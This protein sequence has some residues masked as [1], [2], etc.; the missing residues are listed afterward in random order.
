MLG[1]KEDVEAVKKIYEK[2]IAELNETVEIF[3][4][5]NPKYHR[6][7]IVRSA[8]VLRDIQNQNGGCQI[9]FPK[10]DSGDSKV[11][12]KGSKNCIEAAKQKI[13]E[14]VSDLVK[15]KKFCLP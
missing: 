4:D 15:F 8:E 12:I 13:E 1:K 3:L 9:I 2:Q 11:S 6:H 7:F 10:Q 5:V 14:I